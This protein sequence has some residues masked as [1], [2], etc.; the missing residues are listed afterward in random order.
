MNIL[1]NMRMAMKY[2]H[3]F[4]MQQLIMSRM[5]FRWITKIYLN[6][7]GKFQELLKRID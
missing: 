3:I 1:T 5:A 7:T 4:T 2:L 6:N